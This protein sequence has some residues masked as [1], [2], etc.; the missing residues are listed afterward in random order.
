VL[1]G[2]LAERA[3]LPAVAL[4]TEPFH[5]TGEAMAASWG[6]PRYRFVEM[7]HPIGRLTE[8]EIAAAARALVESVVDLLRT[9]Q[10]A[11]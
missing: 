11:E 6:L 1:D 8:P 4:I 7:P 2:I 3:G 9:G 10:S 5:T